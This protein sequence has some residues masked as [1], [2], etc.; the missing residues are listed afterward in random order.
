MAADPYQ[1]T[2]FVELRHPEWSRDATI[3]QINTRQFTHEGTFR[4]AET[5][6]PRLLELGVGIVWL[7]PVHEIGAVNRKGSLGSP[8]AVKDYDSVNP[9][10]GTVE[11]LRQFVAAAHELGMHVVLDWVA[12]HTAWDC[13]PTSSP[14]TRSGTP[15]GRAA[16]SSPRPGGTGTTSSTSTTAT[17]RCVAT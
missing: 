4:A 15:A 11:D 12:N 1:P 2:P 16:S 17:P 13:N 7:M 6:L 14:S 5:Q 10:F 9:E 8:Y 3:Y